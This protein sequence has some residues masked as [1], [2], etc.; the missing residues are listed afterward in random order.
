MLKEYRAE[1]VRNV[2]IIG[3]GGTGKSTLLEAMLYVS[4]QIDQMGSAEKGTL[5]SDYDDEEKERKISIKSAMSYL[6]HKGVKINVIDTPGTADFIGEMRAALQVAEIAILVVDSVDGVQ[7]ETEKAW[8]YLKEHNIPRII[9]VNK[10]DKERADYNSVIE[11]LKTNLKVNVAPL[12]VPV[13]AG[14]NFKAVVDVIEMKMMEPTGDKRAVERKDI[15]ADMAE[16]VAQE[17]ENLIEQAAEG[18]DE[19]IEKFLEGGEL[20]PEEAQRGLDEQLLEAR[21][22]SVIC[23]SATKLIGIKNLMNVIKHYVP[24]AKKHLVEVQGHEPGNAEAPVAVKIHEDEPFS[25]LVWKTTIDQYTGRI[26]YFKILSGTLTPESELTNSGKEEKERINK[27]YSIMGN[28]LVEVPK[29]ACGD[30][31]IA[32]KLDKTGTGDTLCDPK[33]MVQFDLLDIPHPVFSYAIEAENK[34][35]EDKISQYF[36]RVT[37]EDPTVTY[38]IVAETHETV[39][40]GMGEMQLDMIIKGLREKQ[41]INVITN[42]PKVAYRETITKATEAQY[43]H[44]KQSGG[45]GQYGEVYLRVKPKQRG[46]GFEFTDSIVGGVVPKQYIPG[47]QKGVIEGMDEGVL[48]RYPVVDIGIELFDGS[49]HSVD[50]SE[51]AFKIAARNALKEA[52]KNA[53][54]QLLEPVM[55][56]HIYVD[57]EFMGDVMN[58]ITGRRGRVL[59]MDDAQESGSN[60]SVIRANVPLSEM[61]RY[62]IDL[63]SMTSGKATFE[64][65]FSHYDPISGR[66]ADKVI[67]ARMKDLEEAH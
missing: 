61:L 65:N 56:V 39:L 64:M 43:K 67:E 38:E 23:G 66:V 13:G 53:G 24:C 40:S 25:A 22:S 48:A 10:M 35:D 58:D 11:S 34:G 45:H 4:G 5:V 16:V 63:R 15:P 54:P 59:G 29:L 46:E 28:K 19:L 8:R 27:L 42:E 55:E 1:D 41:K 26:N 31:G 51:M 37:D 17:R 2:A 12:C 30:I 33:R 44:K 32:V 14:D 49:Y 3:H 20:T 50:S 21:L 47:V 60:V 18:D 36:H 62:T 6:E 52:M 9:F 7:I 57:K